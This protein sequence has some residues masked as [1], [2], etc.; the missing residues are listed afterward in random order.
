M[1]LRKPYA[2]LIKYF[3]RINMLLLALVVLTFYQTN[4]LY[5]FVKNYLNT[6][7]YNSTIDSINNYTTGY[8]YLA[9]ILVIIISVILAHLLRRKDKPFISYVYIII[10]NILLFA[11]FLYANYYFTF[12]VTHGYNLVS[13]R[14]INDLFFI[15][16]LPYYPMLFILLIRSIGIDLKSFGFQE[17]K[18]FVEINEEDREEVEVEVGFD[19]DR[20]IRKIKYYFRHTK[21]FILEHKVPLAIVFIIVFGVFGFNFYNYFYVDNRIY[22]MSEQ[23]NSNYYDITINNSYLTDKDYA[24]NVVSEEGTYFIL[25]D[26]TIKNTLSVSRTFDIGKMLLYVDNDYYAP[27][28][29]FNSHFQDMGN[30]YNGK[31]LGAGATSSYLLVYEVPK[32]KDGANIILKYQDAYKGD[33]GKLVQVKIKVLDIS[34]FKDKGSSKLNEEFSIPLNLEEKVTFNISKYR[35][36]SSVNYTY[37]SCNPNS[38]PIYEK[39]IK[40]PKGYKILYMKGTYNDYSAGKYSEFLKKYAKVRYKVDGKIVE[41]DVK[42]AVNSNYLGNHL[43]LLVNDDIKNSDYISLVFTV[44][45]YRYNY[46]IKGE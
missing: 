32:P 31:S 28:T 4:Q 2:F 16:T 36:L 29:K 34:T 5:G 11:L 39:T 12:T 13:A 17:D 14:V 3:R 21:Y 7:F 43:Y 42:L 45:T 41:D 24:G 44:R 37:Q 30:L 40:A 22:S 20:W 1:I 26:A 15:A 25:I 27:T 9:F 10:A 38:C 18:E 8:I 19:K 6:G 33:S 35:I 46:V 23:F